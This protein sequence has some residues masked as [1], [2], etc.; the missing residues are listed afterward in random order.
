MVE[1][2]VGVKF[3]LLEVVLLLCELF[4]QGLDSR[5]DVVG[6][7]LVLVGLARLRDHDRQVRAEDCARDSLDLSQCL[8]LN[9]AAKVTLRGLQRLQGPVASR[10]CSVDVREV[11]DEDGVL[12]SACLLRN[13][14]L[15]GETV[16]L[17]AQ[18]GDLAVQGRDLGAELL[19][20]RVELLDLLLGLGDGIQ[21]FVDLLLAEASVLVVCGGLLLALLLHLNLQLAQELNNLLYRSHRRG[22]CPPRTCC[23]GSDGEQKLHLCGGW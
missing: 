13:L 12:A 11:L 6:V 9:L 21:L 8:E 20:L 1:G 23:R 10:D 5:D 15:L 19:D 18:V 22:L 2:R 3:L 16:D 4:L 17:L 14:H 7:V